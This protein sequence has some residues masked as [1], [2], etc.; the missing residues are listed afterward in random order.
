MLR[1]AAA[2]AF[3]LLR[4]AAR[5]LDRSRIIAAFER[6]EA[7]CERRQVGAGRVASLARQRLHLVAA[8]IERGAIIASP[9]SAGGRGGRR[10]RARLRQR[11]VRHTVQRAPGGRVPRMAGQLGPPEERRAVPHLLLRSAAVPVG[12][13]GV[14]VE[15]QRRGPVAGLQ[16]EQREMPA[17]MA[18]EEAIARI[19]RRARRRGSR[20]RVR[21]RRSRSRHGRTRARR[22]RCRV[23]LPRTARSSAAPPRAAVLA[24]RH[25]MVGQEPEIVAVMRGEA[26]QQRRDRAASARCVR[27][28]ADQSIGVRGRRQAS[29]ASRGHAARCSCRAAIAASV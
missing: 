12:R 27:N 19:G 7:T 15:L 3:A 21:A 20:G 26:V 2:D 13:E 9:R 22:A 16:L 18:V 17:Q 5:A 24:Q 11:A 4:R 14:A 10:A 8:G 25:G 6:D 23:Q 1:A 28:G 29:T